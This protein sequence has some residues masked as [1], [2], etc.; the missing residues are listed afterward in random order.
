[1]ALFALILE[2]ACLFDTVF[3]RSGSHGVLALR[4]LAHGHSAPAS[5]A[6]IIVRGAWFSSGGV[7]KTISRRP[8]VFLLSANVGC[9]FAVCAFWL[10]YTGLPFV[11]EQ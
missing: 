8:M 10:A 11:V 2:Q 1:M 5:G 7:N 6:C 9:V 3:I 4:T